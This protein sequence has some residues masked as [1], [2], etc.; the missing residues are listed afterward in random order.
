M[1][2][3]RL[4]YISS[5][6][7]ALQFLLPGDC[8]YQLWINILHSPVCKSKFFFIYSDL[9]H[10]KQ[11]PA[12]CSQP[13]NCHIPAV[14]IQTCSCHCFCKLLSFILTDTESFFIIPADTESFF[15][16]PAEIPGYL[17]H[18]S[19]VIICLFCIQCPINS[20]SG[21]SVDSISGIYYP[22]SSCYPAF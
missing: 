21:K 22:F 2:P 12:N 9:L 15:I 16:I 20:P 19:S 3:D 18:C 13:A 10:G 5:S 8:L 11:S 6:L 1:L 14:Q 4:L 7:P 17:K